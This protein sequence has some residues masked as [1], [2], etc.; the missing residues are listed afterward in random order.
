M[1]TYILKAMAGV[2]AMLFVTACGGR[3]KEDIIQKARNVSTRSELEKALGKPD[4]IGKLGPVEQ[5]TYKA[6]NGQVVFIIV[7]EQVTLQ[8]T[9]SSDKK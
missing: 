3:T 6:S 9:G 5:W 7:G 2:L 1:K 8:A 4:D